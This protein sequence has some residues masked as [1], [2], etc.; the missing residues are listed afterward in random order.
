MHTA[1]DDVEST[2]NIML[3][4]GENFFMK[5]VKC[6]ECICKQSLHACII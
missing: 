2:C 4:C 1:L 5:A 3:I 6:F